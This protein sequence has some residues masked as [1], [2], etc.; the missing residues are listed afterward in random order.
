MRS[1]PPTRYHQRSASCRDPIRGTE[2]FWRV[3][4]VW[5]AVITLCMTHEGRRCVNG[6]EILCRAHDG[7]C[8]SLVRELWVAPAL[9][10]QMRAH[11]RGCRWKAAQ[12][13]PSRLHSF[14]ARGGTLLPS[15]CS[16]TPPASTSHSV[17]TFQKVS[18]YC[19][20]SL[21]LV[22][23][24]ARR[25]AL[26]SHAS[27]AS[28]LLSPSLTSFPTRSDAAPQRACARPVL[29]SPKPWIVASERQHRK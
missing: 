17:P 19:S 8:P 20:L 7:A 4:R 15:T 24:P 12:L 9:P 2:A 10:R 11:G 14:T 25:P 27:A 29:A 3:R 18:L 28:A 16:Y 22:R 1:G 26:P 6:V 13:P 21:S 5:I 23:P